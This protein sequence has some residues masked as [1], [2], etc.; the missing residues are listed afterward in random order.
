MLTNN[1]TD[2]IH[3]NHEVGYKQFINVFIPQIFT[4]LTIE[5]NKISKPVLQK[6]CKKK[7]EL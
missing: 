7:K 1:V 3:E 4:S 5:K 2:S 6:Q